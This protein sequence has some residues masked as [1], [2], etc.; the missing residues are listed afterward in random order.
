MGDKVLHARLSRCLCETLRYLT[1]R[2]Y[3]DS[4]GLLTKQYTVSP[5]GA[6][7][8]YDS[9]QR[10]LRFGKPYYEWQWVIPQPNTT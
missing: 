5:T 1:G 3:V 9:M 8:R 10:H 7:L 2:F 6:T 4:A